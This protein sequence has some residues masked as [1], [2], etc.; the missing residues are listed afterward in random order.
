MLYTM[1]I[2]FLRSVGRLLVT[3]NVIPSSP[4]PVTMLM[5]ALSYSVPSV[6]T[7]AKRQNIPEDGIPLNYQP[8]NE[9]HGHR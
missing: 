5:E 8:F 3:A 2:V 4:I 9:D 6:L 7:R 1:Y